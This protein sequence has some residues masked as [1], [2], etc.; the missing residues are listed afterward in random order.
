ML[1]VSLTPDVLW[2]GP[3]L[4]EWTDYN[5]HLHDSNYLLIVSLAGDA[6]LDKIG[7]D[8]TGREVTGHSMFTM[9]CHVSYLSELKAGDEAEVRWQLLGADRKRLHLYFSLHKQGDERPAA[10]AE[11]MWLN[12]DMAGPKS[13]PFDPTIQPVI[14]TYVA[15][16]AKQSWPKYAGRSIA[17]PADH[18]IWRE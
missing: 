14:D 17:L 7:L 18:Q 9:E 6:L 3:V 13:A 1:T 8:A 16:H 10:V 4:Q 12:V 15:A 11:Q 2:S 5:G